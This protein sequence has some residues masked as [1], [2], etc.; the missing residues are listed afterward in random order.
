MP[1]R[2]PIDA[3]R[4]RAA[5]ADERYWNAGHPE[6][7]AWQRWVADGYQALYSNDRASGGGGVVHV[8]AYVRDGHAVAAH[9]RGAPHRESRDVGS[10][11]DA[12]D[13]P[14]ADAPRSG[15]SLR[16][17]TTSRRSLLNGGPVVPVMAP[18]RRDGVIGRRP[19][20]ILEGGAGGG[21]A[22]RPSAG[23]SQ[24]QVPS[25]PVISRRSQELVDM[26]AP[27]GRPIGGQQGGARSSIRTLPG[28]EPA[29]E[30]MLQR[31]IN[32][33]GAVDITPPRYSGRMYR[34]DDGTVIGFRPS[35][36]SGSPAVDINIPGY[37]TVRKLHF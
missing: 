29:A 11:S 14:R 18:R 25:P 34:L 1:D 7:G 17:L 27:G 4:L 24:S 26:I 16:D 20:T 9:M 15:S 10:T 37:T 21:G 3:A 33:R 13:R 35:S 8:R 32:G 12:E 22:H 30:A 28:G 5:V 36:A 23:Q 6:R 31:L 19:D 2:V